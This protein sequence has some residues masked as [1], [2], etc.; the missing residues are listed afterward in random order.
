MVFIM[1]MVVAGELLAMCGECDWS[2]EPTCRCRSR[3]M[4]G[5]RS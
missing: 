1:E 5:G 4:A 2:S 3:G